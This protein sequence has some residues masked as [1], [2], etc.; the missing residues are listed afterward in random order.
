MVETCEY[1]RRHSQTDDLSNQLSAFY[2]R[3]VE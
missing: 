1:W 3:G 2:A